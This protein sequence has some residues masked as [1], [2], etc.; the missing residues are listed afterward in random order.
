MTDKNGRVDRVPIL[1]PLPAFWSKRVLRG[2]GGS[3]ILPDEHVRLVDSAVR[4]GAVR[5]LLD[6]GRH[7]DSVTCGSV[8]RLPQDSSVLPA[9]SSNV[10]RDCGLF[11]LRAE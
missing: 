4:E 5:G 2:R 10:R 9:S 7:H 6:D 8:G 3:S 1:V 11:G